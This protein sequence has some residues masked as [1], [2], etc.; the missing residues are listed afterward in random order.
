M[1]IKSEKAG[2]SVIAYILGEIDHHNAKNARTI[3]DGI[4]LRERPV[5]FSLD[6]SA[7]SFCDSSGLGL[8]MGRMKKCTRIYVIILVDLKRRFAEFDY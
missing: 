4:I 1:E 6:L 2:S 7:V 3:L 5:N 8:V